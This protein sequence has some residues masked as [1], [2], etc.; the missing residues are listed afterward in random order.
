MNIRSPHLPKVQK[1][2]QSK[3][4]SSKHQSLKHARKETK[5]NSNLSPNVTFYLHLCFSPVPVLLL[6]PGRSCGPMAN[7]RLRLY[8]HAH[9]FHKTLRGEALHLAP[10][11]SVPSAFHVLLIP[12]PKITSQFDSAEKD[13]GHSVS[14]SETACAWCAFPGIWPIFPTAQTSHRPEINYL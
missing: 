13:Q 9:G 7:P 10:F 5:T 12:A 14:A 4:I 2:N 8:M 3:S 6:L 1:K 11:A